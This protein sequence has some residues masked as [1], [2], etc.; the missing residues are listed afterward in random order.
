M[1][2]QAY[3]QWKHRF[4]DK[5]TLNSGLSF[6]HYQLSNKAVV[7]PRLGAI[8]A[9]ND[10]SSLSVAYGLHSNLQPVLLSFYQTQNPD[11]TYS[12]NNRD[13]GF[14]RSH[15]FV[16]GYQRTSAQTCI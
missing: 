3:L 11:G 10:R 2:S 16:A 8:Y 5:L 4:T 9:L 1:L 7:E 14:T 6:M 15:H 12:L 13:M